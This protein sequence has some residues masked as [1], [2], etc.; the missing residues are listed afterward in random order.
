VAVNGSTL[1]QVTGSG[2]AVMLE[3]L[4]HGPLARTDLA[5]RLGLSPASLTRLT[6]PLVE[7]GL[8]AETSARRA[9]GAGR[10]SRPLEVVPNACRFVGVKLTEDEAYGVVT[11]LRADVLASTVAP[12]ADRAPD[13]VVEVVAGLVSELAADGRPAVF[14]GVSLG[15]DTRDHSTVIRAPFLGWHDVALADLL[16]RATGLPVVVDNDLVALTKAE[17]WFGAG[18]GRERFALLTIGAGVGHGLVVHDDVVVSPDAGVGLLGHV[19]LDPMGPR[20]F[21]GHRGCATAMLTIPA[22]TSAVSVGL[23]R[24]VDYP[25][26]L[27]LAAAG[28]PVAEPIVR[29]AGRALGRLVALVS[30]VTMTNHVVLAGDGIRL[31]EVARDAL[32]DAL[33]EERDPRADAVELEI[34]TFGFAEWARGAAASAIQTWAREPISPTAR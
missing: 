21:L 31:A 19:P 16:E 10:P 3:V 29:D 5:R 11:N 27:T 1:G 30:N 2:H 26:S 23:G 7:C 18:R 15:G 24:Q 20:C 4:R 34:Q 22:I 25:E 6:A 32:T 8:L 17:H 33:S 12:L 9:A 28:D 14:L 13:P